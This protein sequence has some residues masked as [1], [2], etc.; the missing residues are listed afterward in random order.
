[1]PIPGKDNNMNRRDLFKTLAIGG[2][3]ALIAS[4]GKK[5]PP[6]LQDLLDHRHNDGFP[7]HRRAQHAEAGAIQILMSWGFS[8]K[9]AEYYKSRFLKL[10]DKT[11]KRFSD[12]TE[13]HGAGGAI[14]IDFEN[15]P[16]VKMEYQLIFKSSSKSRCD[17]EM[18][19]GD[20]GKA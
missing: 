1:M 13:S 16:F 20:M 7:K 19:L 10:G 6:T 5:K 8:R 17:V 14:Y 11:W 3:G 15:K 12:R 9:E 18:E 4:C 2:I